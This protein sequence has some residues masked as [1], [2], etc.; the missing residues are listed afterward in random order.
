MI[1]GR[2]S[3]TCAGPE[4]FVVIVAAKAKL[5]DVNHD[6]SCSVRD[7]V[8]RSPPLPAQCFMVCETLKP[9]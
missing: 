4:A 7:V 5:I 3:N 6:N 8:Y 9:G 2:F 1:T